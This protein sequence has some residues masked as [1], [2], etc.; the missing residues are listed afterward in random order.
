MSPRVVPLTPK[1]AI[2]LDKPGA[3]HKGHDA[4]SS[5]DTGSAHPGA[6]GFVEGPRDKDVEQSSESCPEDKCMTLVR[7]PGTTLGLR[8]EEA[9]RRPGPVHPV[10]RKKETLIQERIV[11]YTT[12][13]DEGRVSDTIKATAS[14]IVVDRC[15]SANKQP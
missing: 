8:G 14:M 15:V 7:H 5:F 12:L 10:W 11:Q 1:S 13:D 3:R 2:A 4:S 9:Y 6:D